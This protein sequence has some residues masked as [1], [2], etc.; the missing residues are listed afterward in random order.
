MLEQ[1]IIQQHPILVILKK[2]LFMEIR[3]K[4]Y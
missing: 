4:Y 1:Q 3:L 2:Y